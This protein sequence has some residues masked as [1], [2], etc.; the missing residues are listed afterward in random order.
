MGRLIVIAA[1]ICLAPTAAAS[2]GRSLGVVSVTVSGNGTVT[3]VPAGIA[4]PSACALQ[5]SPRA[6]VTLTARPG[7]GAA[8]VGWSG[9]CTSANPQCRLDASA[10]RRVTAAFGA[11]RVDVDRDGH[12]TPQDCNDGNAAIHP[13][14]AEIAGNEVDENCDGR[15]APFPVLDVGVRASW[16][17]S[18]VRTRVVAL[19]VVRVPARAAVRVTCRSTRPADC[20][21]AQRTPAVRTAGR[22]NLIGLFGPEPQKRTFR[23]GTKI[24]VRVTA[25][26]Q[27]GKVF[28]FVL[29]SGKLPVGSVKCVAPGSKTPKNC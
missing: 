11:A 29:Q 22:M 1:A 4:C 15:A 9:A 8:F 16:R 20:P 21:F 12:A 18:G 23:P 26:G 24:E 14:A 13:A 25:P 5:F 7:R 6:A 10:D 28:T 17:I 27:I 19:E 3:S 2:S